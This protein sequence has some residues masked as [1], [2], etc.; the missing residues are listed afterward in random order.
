MNAQQPMNIFNVNKQSFETAAFENYR[1]QLE[2]NRVYREYQS[3][4]PGKLQHPQGLTTFP[5]LPI[6]F[7]KSKR[8]V[9]FEGK[10][11][12]IFTSSGT[13]GMST[14]K[15]F[16]K[17]L[18]LYESSFLSAFRQFYGDASQYAFLCLLPS[19][20]EREGSSL[21]YMAERLVKDSGNPDCGFFLNAGKELRDVLNRREMEGKPSFLLGVTFALLDFAEVYPM[22]LRQT[23]VMET[24]G[25]KGRK[26][27]I[28]RGEVHEQLTAAF[29]LSSVHSEYGMT[30]LLSQA[31]SKGNGIFKAPPWMKL[32]VRDEDDPFTMRESGTGLLCVVDLA[33]LFS[34]SF[35]ETSDLG[36]VYED[37]SFEVLGRID[38]SDIRGCSLLI[39]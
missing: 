32:L 39:T 27:E 34:C 12:M 3:L 13:T 35:I 28:T 25:M 29:D 7:F 8:V 23:I 5:F 36:T 2:N 4:L 22:P 10:E 20:M 18:E 37:G 6:N 21:I 1:F 11:E 24:G 26:K 15:H 16:V 33:N 30:E 19:Y 17:S 38:N 14:S 9:A 31:Y